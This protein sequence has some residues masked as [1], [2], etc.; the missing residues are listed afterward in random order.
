MS[1][2]SLKFFIV[3]LSMSFTAFVFMNTYE[4]VFNRDVAV[5]NSVRQFAMQD[6]LANI[7]KQFDIEPEANSEKVNAKYERLAYLQFPSLSANLYL[8]ERR[9]INGSWYVRPNLAHY[10]ELNKDSRGVAV[11]YLVYARS[12]WQT[13]A[14]PN[15]IELGSDVR[16]FH[17]GQKVATFKVQ[18]KEVLPFSSSFVAGKSESRQII[19]LIE[20]PDSRTYFA[21]SLVLKD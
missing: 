9:V 5:A 4:V 12:S 2:R 14:T 3:A 19:L 20:D 15:D 16:L 10:I 21:Y 8:E 6:Q 1:S 11:D 17:D 7:I 18:E 13:I